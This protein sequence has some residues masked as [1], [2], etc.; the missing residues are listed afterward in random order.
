MPDEAPVT[1]ALRSITSSS[2]RAGQ[3]IVKRRLEQPG[4]YEPADEA[5]HMGEEGDSAAALRYAQREVGV[6]RLE[7]DPV[8]DE[9]H[10]GEADQEERH[11]EGQHSRPGVEEDVGGEDAGDGAAGAQRGHP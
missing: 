4:Q 10:R 11:D 3:R 8:A 6:E 2:N 9:D 5:A 1:S 7:R